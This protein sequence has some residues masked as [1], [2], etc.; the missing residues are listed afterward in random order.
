[1]RLVLA[2]GQ[3]APAAGDISDNIRHIRSLV[4]EAS[5]QGA[6][7]LVLPE[8]CLCGY[9]AADQARARAVRPDGPEMAE[10]GACAREAGVALCAVSY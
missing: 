7:L 10:L 8:L 3:F 4:R 2:C 6:G 9:P 1:M 5:R